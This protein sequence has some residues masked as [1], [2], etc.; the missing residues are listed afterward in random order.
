[1]NKPKTNR[2]ELTLFLIVAFAVP[3]LMGIPLAFA[4]RAGQ[5]TSLFANA[6]MMYPAA[7]V[8][9]AFMAVR[10][11]ALP[12]RFYALHI[13]STVACAVCSLLSV[14]MPEQSW[15]VYINILMIVTSVLGWVLLLTEKKEKRAAAGLRW[16]GKIRT[17]LGV[18]LLFFVLKTA[19]MFLSAALSGAEY[20]S[21][22]LAYWQSFVP[23]YYMLLL[24]PTSFSA[25]C[26]FLG[27]NTAG[28]TIS[29]RC[30]SSGSASA[31]GCCCW[32]CCGGSG[33]C[34]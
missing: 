17:A 22:Y 14:F 26:R 34:R 15:V 20:W 9:L 18:C 21:E 30:C 12:M 16:R 33:I 4:Q 24:I 27:R 2:R 32:A 1:M 8:M 29:P 23:W 11:T 3:Y 19:M 28:G 13:V 25:S 6:Q 5:D 10:R 7:G 31:A